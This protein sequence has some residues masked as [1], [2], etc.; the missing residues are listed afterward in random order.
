MT[1]RGPLITRIQKGRIPQQPQ[2]TA[3]L[4]LNTLA[5]SG[6]VTPPFRKSDWP[7]PLRKPLGL[8]HHAFYGVMLYEEST[9]AP[10]VPNNWQ[11]PVIAKRVQQPTQLR[12]FNEFF[13]AAH[14][15]HNRDWKN[16]ILAKRQVQTELAPN[17]VLNTL[18]SPPTLPKIQALWQ[19]PIIAPRVQQPSP[20][21]N[22]LATTLA[23]APPPAVPVIR[24]E[25]INPVVSRP[26]NQPTLSQSMLA[27]SVV[28]VP[29]FRFDWQLPIK[30]RRVQQPDILPV[31][32]LNTLYTDPPLPL[33]TQSFSNPLPSRVVQQPYVYPYLQGST[34]IPTGD[35][36]PPGSRVTTVFGPDSIIV[37]G[38]Y[39]VTFRA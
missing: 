15:L 14:P 1:I 24:N 4:L 19:R 35:P 38:P 32:V 23:N 33:V 36:T 12:N 37:Y 29:Q 11:N 25:W 5:V 28:D 31:L 34:L 8:G 16:P 7:N 13:V 21:L 18:Y 3:N 10:F 26:R 2:V 9:Q 20:A 39:S 27:L 17:L 6:P 30:A 22:L